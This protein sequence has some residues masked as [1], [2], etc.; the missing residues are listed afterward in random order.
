[1]YYPLQPVCQ[2]NA[3]PNSA[4]I[5]IMIDKAF[6]ISSEIVDISFQV[7]VAPKRKDPTQFYS[8]IL[9]SR[10]KVVA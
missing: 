4:H 6:S 8:T 1:M 7:R 10:L 3:N 9:K 2:G 5:L